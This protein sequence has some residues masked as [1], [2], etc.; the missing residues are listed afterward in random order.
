MAAIVRIFPHSGLITAPVAAGSGRLSTDSVGLLKQPPLG[1]EKLTTDTT[2]VASSSAATASNTSTR[3]VFIQVQANKIV[4]YE[5][6]PEGQELV[7]AGDT[8]PTI[9]GE[10]VLQF[11]PG[12]RISFLESDDA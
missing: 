8:S 1:R 6:T 10:T 5:C 2:T 11:G 4:H 12:W 3:I 7:E 9:T